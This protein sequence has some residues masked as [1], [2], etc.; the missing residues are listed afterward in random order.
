AL[1][2]LFVGAAAVGALDVGEDGVEVARGAVAALR[3]GAGAAAGGALEDL[4]RLGRDDLGDE[5][6]D[7]ALP[8]LR[9][10]GGLPVLLVD[11][12]VAVVVEVEPLE[13]LGV[14]GD[15]A[16][17]GGGEDAG[18]DAGGEPGLGALTRS[19]RTVSAAWRFASSTSLSLA[20]RACSY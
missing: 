19:E 1:P 14:V 3:A 8:G 10:D 5:G 18:L 7:G 12:R 11:L 16:G 6:V 17:D 2:R 13:E 15:A 4:L 9:H 20:R